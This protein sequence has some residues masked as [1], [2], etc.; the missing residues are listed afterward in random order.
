MFVWDNIGDD[1]HDESREFQLFKS[2]LEKS[3]A[4][5]KYEDQPRAPD[6]NLVLERH[7]MRIQ[8]GLAYAKCLKSKENSNKLL[9]ND[10]LNSQTEIGIR[11]IISLDYS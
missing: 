11:F 5:S 7:H 10:D 1:G 2:D 4:G 8:N 6:L 3:D 9:P